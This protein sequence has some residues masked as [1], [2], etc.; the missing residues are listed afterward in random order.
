MS[1]TAGMT[2]TIRIRIEPEKKAALTR[3]YQSR[4]M[5][6]SQAVRDFLDDEL[7]AMGNPLDRF[8]AI[9]ASVDERL[10]AYDGPEPTIDDI[11]AY[12]EKVRSARVCDSVA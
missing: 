3:L 2:E 10:K 6:I 9:M 7:E 12:V 5:H 4:G 11:V 1:A 8:D